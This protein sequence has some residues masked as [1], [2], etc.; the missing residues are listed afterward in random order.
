MHKQNA[1]TQTHRHMHTQ[2]HIH[3]QPKVSIQTQA[4][5]HFHA[6]TPAARCGCALQ[7]WGSGHP[8]PAGGTRGAAEA[9]GRGQARKEAG[10]G[11]GCDNFRAGQ[12]GG[13]MW[14]FEMRNGPTC[15]MGADGCESMQ[16][17]CPANFR[18]ILP[19]SSIPFGTFLLSCCLVFLKKNFS[20]CISFVV[21]MFSISFF[22]FFFAHFNNNERFSFYCEGWRNC[23]AVFCLVFFVNFS[24]YS[25]AIFQSSPGIIVQRKRPRP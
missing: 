19:F 24:L 5:P 8:P 17:V 14:N 12:D 25:C 1:D 23:A 13:G 2:T 16:G 11:E 22:V 9:P 3:T 10:R 7:R 18:Q 21:F 4:T 20:C 6:H 15:T